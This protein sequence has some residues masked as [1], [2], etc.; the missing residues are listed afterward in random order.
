MNGFENHAGFNIS[1]SRLQVV[2]V[3]FR[4]DQFFL[5]NIDEVYFDDHINF[6]EDKETKITSLLQSAFNELV[7][8]NPLSSSLVSFTLPLS[9][10]M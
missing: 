1:S 10:F 8:K 3:N 5:H 6:L 4:N 7:I 9:C 2:E